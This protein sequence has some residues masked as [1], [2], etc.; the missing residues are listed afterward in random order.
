MRVPVVG[1]CCSCSDRTR[2]R[3]PDKTVDD[4]GSETIP[5]RIHQH[6]H[7]PPPPFPF[8]HTCTRTHLTFPR[9]GGC[10]LF[11]QIIPMGSVTKMYTA[12]IVLRLQEQGIISID[13]PVASLGVSTPPG[14]L[15]VT[16]TCHSHVSRARKNDRSHVPTQY[17]HRICRTDTR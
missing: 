8:P 7:H 5:N 1:T 9:F 13:D 3:E 10:F 15:R 6:H 12:V 4:S 14:T 2:A 17:T 16:R 11:F